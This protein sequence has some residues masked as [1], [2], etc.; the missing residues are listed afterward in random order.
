MGELAQA[1]EM[2][3][4]VERAVREAVSGVSAELEGLSGLLNDLRSMIGELRGAAEGVPMVNCAWVLKIVNQTEEI[5]G[6]EPK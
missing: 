1:V 5:L 3:E 4:S 2:L 6:E